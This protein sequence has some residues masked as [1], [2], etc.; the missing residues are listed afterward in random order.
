MSKKPAAKKQKTNPAAA[1]ASLFRQDFG[2]DKPEMVKAPAL[3]IGGRQWVFTV[4]D[5]NR[6]EDQL[7]AVTHSRVFMP[8]SMAGEASA[9]IASSMEMGLANVAISIRAVNDV[10]LWMLMEQLDSDFKVSEEE[11]GRI[12]DPMLPPTEVRNRAAQSF[13]RWTAEQGFNAQITAWLT[14]FLDQ[15]FSRNLPT[16]EAEENSFSFKCGE[17]D[18]IVTFDG[19]DVDDLRERIEEHGSVLCPRC[20]GESKPPEAGDD[21]PLARRFGRK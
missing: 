11:R 13:L 15:Q 16:L 19:P 10:P 7:W 3:T 14:Q 2:L 6:H 1:L 21:S 5:P 12:R 4:S 9:R 20:G 17:C 18:Y 8:A